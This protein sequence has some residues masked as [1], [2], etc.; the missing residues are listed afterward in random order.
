MN[1]NDERTSGPWPRSLPASLLAL[2]V[3]CLVGCQT[4]GYKKSDSA[5]REAQ[6]AATKIQAVSTN[7]EATTGA[8]NDLVNQP[9]L[10][11]KPQF[12]R[13]RAALDHLLASA[14]RADT[15]VASLGR[16][17][18][19]YFQIWEKEIAAIQDQEIRNRSETRKAEVSAQVIA[20]NR[21]NDQACNDRQPV[22]G[23]LQDIRKALSTDLTRQ[24]LTAVQPWVINVNESARKLQTSLAQSVTEMDTLSARMSSARVQEPK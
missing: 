15:C 16:K 8:L 13:F 2:A 22:F 3:A 4:A 18:A 10:D 5:A 17:Q 14:G 24:G 12:L 19:A 11:A 7:L 9:A 21:Q 20:A 23:Y 1:P 6:T